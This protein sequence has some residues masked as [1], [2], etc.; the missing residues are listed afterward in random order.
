MPQ[1]KSYKGKKVGIA[2]I[3]VKFTRRIVKD[4]LY[5]ARTRLRDK[6]IRDLGYSVENKIHLAES[7]TE[8]NRDL[9][10]DSLTAKKGHEV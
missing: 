4:K 2:P 1:S 10:K 8:K 5:R 3:I 9:F 6:T 7:L